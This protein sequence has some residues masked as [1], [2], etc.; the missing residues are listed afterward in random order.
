MIFNYVFLRSLINITFG[1]NITLDCSF[2]K[3]SLA[4][5]S[6]KNALNLFNSTQQIRDTR[7]RVST[8]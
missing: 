1:F 8:R 3:F 6:L 2:K 5:F 4:S 7:G